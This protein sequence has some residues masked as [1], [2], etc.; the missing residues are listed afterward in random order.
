MTPDQ[1]VY[2]LLTS[3]RVKN[4]KDPNPVDPANPKTRRRHDY[5][6]PN[7]QRAIDMCEEIAEQLKGKPFPP[8]EPPEWMKHDK[9][10]VAEWW[11]GYNKD[12]QRAE[13][14]AQRQTAMQMA[15]QQTAF[16][17]PQAAP[18]AAQTAADQQNA[19]AWA[20]YYAQLQQ[21]QHQ[22]AQPQ[23]ATDPNAAAWASYYAQQ[24]QQ[25]QPLPAPA[26]PTGDQSA[27]LQAVLAA[28]SGTPA[29]ATQAQQQSAAANSA[30]DPQIQALLATLGATTSVQQQPT[31]AYQPH[32]QPAQSQAPNPQDSK[33]LAYILSL[34]SGHTTIPSQQQQQQQQA[35]QQPPSIGQRRDDSHDRARD[36][37]RDSDRDREPESLHT[38]RRTQ[39]RGGKNNRGHIWNDRRDWVDENCRHSITWTFFGMT[40]TAMMAAHPRARVGITT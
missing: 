24:Q 1:Q 27:Q 32:P 25:Q 37:D 35:H 14:V 15:Q 11:H 7:L 23:A 17:Q 3:S 20:A 22:Q 2:A 9:D 16:T 12:K 13:Q 36:R 40:Q 34:A 5:A 18:Q 39:N 33:Y 30:A 28:L 6:D 31:Q 29:Q 8:A 38:S 4:W 10:R 19:A 26:Q 21:Q